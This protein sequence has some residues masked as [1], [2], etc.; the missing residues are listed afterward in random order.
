MFETKIKIGFK[1][2]NQLPLFMIWREYIENGEVVFAEVILMS[3]EGRLF[4]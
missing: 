3:N 1:N 2:E 4:L